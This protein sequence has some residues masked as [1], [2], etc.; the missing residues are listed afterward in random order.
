VA[1]ALLRRPSWNTIVTL[2]EVN[3]AMGGDTQL[4]RL[5][6][7][8]TKAL[9]F[10]VMDG[11]DALP[12]TSNS[13]NALLLKNGCKRAGSVHSPCNVNM[14]PPTD[15]TM[16]GAT[17]YTGAAPMKLTSG[18]R[19]LN[20]GIEFDEGPL[21]CIE[22]NF[23]T[24]LTPIFPWLLSVNQRGTLTDVPF[25]IEMDMVGNRS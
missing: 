24:Y 14:V 11:L 25:M 2:A 8:E 15:A 7:E 12:K 3:S 4:F 21:S 10:T 9:D 16:V 23:Q 20:V 22:E 5:A 13:Q 18:K 17:S 6:L 19:T 1:A